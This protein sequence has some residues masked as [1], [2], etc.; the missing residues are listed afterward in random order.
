MHTSITRSRRTKEMQAVI[1]K[2][3]ACDL[4]QRHFYKQE[5]LPLSTFTYWLRRCRRHDSPQANSSAALIPIKV[6]VAVS[7]TQSSNCTIE[8]PGSA[9]PPGS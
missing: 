2:Y 8:L 3:H 7:E 4:T 6:K 5:K 9:I 1:E